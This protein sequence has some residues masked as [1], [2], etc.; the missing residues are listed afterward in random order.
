MSSVILGCTRSF[1]RV[2]PPPIGTWVTAT[3]P[4]R[5]DLA[6]GWTDTPPITYELKDG[7]MVVN[8]AIKL[9]GME[10]CGSLMM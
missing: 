6:G 8:V 1:R 9:D 7:G 5:A 3:S 10:I 2:T 4:I